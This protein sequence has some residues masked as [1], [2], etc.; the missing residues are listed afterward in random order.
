[1]D[2]YSLQYGN[3][4]WS[5]NR[6]TPK[7][8]ISVG[9][10]IINPYKASSYWG[11]WFF[12]ED[13]IWLIYGW[14]GWAIAWFMWLEHVGTTIICIWLRIL[15]AYDN[16]VFCRETYQPTRQFSWLVRWYGEWTRLIRNGNFYYWISSF[17]WPIWGLWNIYIQYVVCVCLFWHW[18][19]WNPIRIPEDRTS[20]RCSV[21]WRVVG[22]FT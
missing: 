14:Y 15:I 16:P 3:K 2:V 19:H 10:S 20:G 1:M 13:P 11:T 8:T 17:C 6:G 5:W 21:L 12:K 9:F 22:G 18:N 7:S 4:F